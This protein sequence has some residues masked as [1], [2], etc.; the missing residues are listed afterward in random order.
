[1]NILVNKIEIISVSSLARKTN[2]HEKTKKP[3]ETGFPYHDHPVDLA[4]KLYW[5]FMFVTNKKN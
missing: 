4:M 3:Y 2:S 5:L 1:M